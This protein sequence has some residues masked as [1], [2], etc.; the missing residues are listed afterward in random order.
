MAAA[1]RKVFLPHKGVTWQVFM[2]PAGVTT[3]TIDA[4]GGGGGG[5]AG[6][7]TSSYDGGQGGGAGAVIRCRVA[8][9]P[10][11]AVAFS[12][13]RG[14]RGGPHFPN[15]PNRAPGS[16]GQATDMRSDDLGP[17]SPRATAGA[18]AASC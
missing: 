16:G 6:T 4:V 11:M 5:G 17:S 7:W 1:K 12:V 8:V 14:G 18:T 10:R 13:G 3:L 15:D 2:V 9:R